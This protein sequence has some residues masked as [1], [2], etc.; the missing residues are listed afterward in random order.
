MI[1]II[2]TAIMHNMVPVLI[3]DQSRP[4]RVS[5]S[6]LINNSL[7]LVTL[8][9]C[10]RSPEIVVSRVYTVFLHLNW[11]IS[12]LVCSYEVVFGGGRRHMG[13]S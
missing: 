2:L 13:L 5:I 10:V 8:L 7:D 4:S 1:A 6:R 9:F 3:H 11:L 12:L